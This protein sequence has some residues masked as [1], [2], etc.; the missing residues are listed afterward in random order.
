[1]ARLRSSA[2]LAPK[3][4][5]EQYTRGYQYRPPVPW[6]ETLGPWTSVWPLGNHNIPK[7]ALHTLHDGILLDGAIRPIWSVATATVNDRQVVGDYEFQILSTRY[8]FTWYIDHADA[9][10]LKITRDDGTSTS[11]VDTGL[12]PGP[13][14]HVVAAPWQNVVYWSY[15]ASGSILKLVVA[16]MVHSSVAASPANV[17]FMLVLDNNL[18]VIRQ[19]GNTFIFQWSV[20]S[21]PEDFA[22]A[23]SGNFPLDTQH[24][25][26]QALLPF[27]ADGMILHSFGGTAVIPTGTA[28]PAFRKEDRSDLSGALWTH[29]AASSG[30]RLYYVSPD[31]LLRVYDGG[32]RFAGTGQDR[33]LRSVDGAEGRGGIG[34]AALQQ[35]VVLFY[36]Q[37]MNMLFMSDVVNQHTDILDDDVNNWVAN[38]DAGWHWITDS[39]SATIEGKIVGVR[40]DSVGED[41]FTHTFELNPAIFAVPRIK[42][43]RYYIGREVWF[44]QVDVIRLDEGTPAQLAMTLKVNRGDNQESDILFAGALK[45]HEQGTFFS[46]YPNTPA[47]IYQIELSINQVEA[48][49]DGPFLALNGS[50]NAPIALDNSGD[51]ADLNAAGNG[52]ITGGATQLFANSLTLGG[53]LLLDR[54]SLWTRD[55]GIERIEIYGSEMI[56]V[57]R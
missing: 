45:I 13:T 50:G 30:A 24:G 26:P 27:R 14:I 7:D 49:T 10:K 35:Q 44:T 6:R 40:N 4:T 8:R 19:S 22:G 55:S 51:R 15:Q 38:K 52:V 18:T 32:E 25:R 54:V 17:E 42:T 12:T 39:P 28:S 3:H 29:V 37:R 46:Y 57:G 21:T 11:T 1:M 36:S 34:A 56:P 31:R 9:D 53:N 47:K 20:D 5:G 2:M 43:G 33:T 16:T 48:S 23:G 41:Y